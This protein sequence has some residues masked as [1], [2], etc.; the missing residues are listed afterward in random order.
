MNIVTVSK[1][2]KDQKS[3]KDQVVRGIDWKAVR[4]VSGWYF[5]ALYA[6][7]DTQKSSAAK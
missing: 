5:Q 7:R 4:I 6:H 3:K 2:Q 1:E